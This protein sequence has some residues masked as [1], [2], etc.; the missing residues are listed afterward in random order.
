MIPSPVR[1]PNVALQPRRRAEV[2]DFFDRRRAF[3]GCKRLLGDCRTFSSSFIASSE[4]TR[5]LRKSALERSMIFRNSGCQLKATDSRS[6]FFSGTIAATARLRSVR[7]TI[8]SPRSAAYSAS[9]REACDNLIVF[10]AESPL[11]RSERRSALSRQ[12]PESGR[13]PGGPRLHR[14]TPAAD[15]RSTPSRVSFRHFDSMNGWI[16]SA[17]ATA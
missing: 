11:H 8:S 9:G 3:V 2:F 16:S 14:K 12:P 13:L 7:A 1:L 10:T 17:S 4:M 15:T 6:V 5:R